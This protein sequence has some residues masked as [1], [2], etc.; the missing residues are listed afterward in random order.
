MEIFK[1]R[2]FR[3]PEESFVFEPSISF[4]IIYYFWWV[5]GQKAPFF[6]KILYL[7]NVIFKLFGGPQGS[8]S[9]KILQK[10]V[11]KG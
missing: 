2:F 11:P 8:P 9:E 1:K 4:I 10:I 6:K 5:V 3:G 7:E